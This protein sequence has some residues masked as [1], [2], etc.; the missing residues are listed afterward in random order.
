MALSSSRGL[1]RW[2][3]SKQSIQIR[4][5]YQPIGFGG[6]SDGLINYE[7]SKDIKICYMSF[8]AAILFN[9]LKY[10]KE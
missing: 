3:S 2:P 5:F 7:K 4:G 10:I 6:P 1:P 9:L 8:I